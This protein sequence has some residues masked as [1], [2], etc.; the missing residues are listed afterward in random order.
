MKTKINSGNKLF[1]LTL[2]WYNS[3]SVEMVT[4]GLLVLTVLSS[5]ELVLLNLITTELVGNPNQKML[6]LKVMPVLLTKYK[7][8]LTDMSG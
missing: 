8:V 2:T 1:H 5:S 6:P 3:L 7:S 4:F